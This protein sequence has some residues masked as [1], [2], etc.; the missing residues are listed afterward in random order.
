MATAKQVR[1]AKQNVN[2]AQS[3]ARQ[4]RTIA[5]MPASKRSA[6]GKQGAALGHE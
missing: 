2:K 1:A 4:D 6:L 5:H 3:A